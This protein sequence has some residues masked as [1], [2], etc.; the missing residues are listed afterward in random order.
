MLKSLKIAGVGLGALLCGTSTLAAQE[1]LTIEVR[2]LM[3][4]MAQKV[5]TEAQKKCEEMGFKVSATVVDRSGNLQ[6]MLRDPLAGAHSIEVSY[7]KAWTS[8]S[9]GVATA[10]MPEEEGIE[11][12]SQ[13]I[14][15]TGGLPIEIGG[16][17]YGGVGVS[18][19]TSEADVECAQHGIEAIAA[20]LE[21]ME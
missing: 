19:A 7:R 18:G 16:F 10:D 12:A 5:V 6:A 13:V 14:R 15:T 9:F 4:S 8:A 20:D 11:F 3:P 2:M 1:I 21:F 17:S